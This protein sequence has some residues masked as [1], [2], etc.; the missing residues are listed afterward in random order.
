MAYIFP[1]Q[2]CSYGIYLQGQT[3]K[4]LTPK[5]NPISTSQAIV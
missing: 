4:T 5:V 2:Y 1:T 3:N